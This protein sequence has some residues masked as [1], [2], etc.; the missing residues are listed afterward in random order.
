MWI[1]LWFCSS[2]KIT[3]KTAEIVST[4]QKGEEGSEPALQKGAQKPLIRKSQ[5]VTAS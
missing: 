5:V 3:H 4:E 1:L 2:S